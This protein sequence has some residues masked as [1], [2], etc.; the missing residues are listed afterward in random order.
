[1]AS[2]PWFKFYAADY[3]LDARVDSLSLEAQAILLR[4]WCLC[5]IEGSC[6]A[7]SN[8]IAR[9]SRLTSEQI[10]RHLS[11]LLGFFE[12]RDGRLY[13]HRMEAEKLKSET[14]RRNGQKRGEQIRSA[15]RRLVDGSADCLAQSQSQSQNQSKGQIQTPPSLKESVFVSREKNYSQSDFDE[16][17][18]RLF[19][20]A[21]REL[22]LKLANGLQMT[23]DEVFKYQCAKA[24]KSPQRM[25]EIL[26][27]VEGA[28]A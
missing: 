11:N 25:T 26:A 12:E 23:S 27:R 1:M 21:G 24:G 15:S 7:E 28:S 4:L 14:A 16:E 18:Y 3:L 8:E 19:A 2:E 13:S 9:K 10:G 17:A 6:P 5:H 20:K 22:E